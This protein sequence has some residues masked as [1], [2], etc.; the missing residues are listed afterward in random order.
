MGGSGIGT[1]SGRGSGCGGIGGS[2]S[3]GWGGCGSGM[4]MGRP[5]PIRAGANQPPELGMRKLS[6]ARRQDAALA[7]ALSIGCS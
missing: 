2:G 1:G 4:L 5:Y 7:C 6:L 3:G